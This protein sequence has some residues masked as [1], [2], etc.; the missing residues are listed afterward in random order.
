M[1]EGKVIKF[2]YGTVGVSCLL[3][4][5]A[6]RTI[7]PPVEVGGNVRREDTEFIGEPLL[8]DMGFYYDKLVGELEKVSPSNILS[9]DVGDYTLDFSNY[10]PKSVEVVIQFATLARNAFL[11]LCAC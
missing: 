5:V 6:F 2:G 8:I 1:V 9:V 10:N 4:Y 3:Q 7:K 11:N